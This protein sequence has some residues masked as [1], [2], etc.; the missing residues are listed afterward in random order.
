MLTT[1]STP[2]PPHSHCNRRQHAHNTTQPRNYFE[3]LTM[4]PQTQ[5]AAMLER[6]KYCRAESQNYLRHSVPAMY[7]LEAM[8][9]DLEKKAAELLKESTQ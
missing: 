7:Q 4:S 8:A 6:A 5:A 1:S 2:K 9:E 3:R